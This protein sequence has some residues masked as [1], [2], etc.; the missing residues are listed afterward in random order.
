MGPSPTTI[1]P[2]L[3]RATASFVIC[4]MDLL[5]LLLFTVDNITNFQF[6]VKASKWRAASL[7][8]VLLADFFYPAGTIVLIVIGILPEYTV[9]AKNGEGQTEMRWKFEV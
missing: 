7:F 6:I 8:Q 9:V 5:L 3:A 1:L 2:I 4:F